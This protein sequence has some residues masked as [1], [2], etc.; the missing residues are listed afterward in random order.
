MN[1]SLDDPKTDLGG[2]AIDLG[3]F[4]NAVNGRDSFKDISIELECSISRGIS[5]LD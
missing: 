1:G 5:F 4:M 3:G 2:G